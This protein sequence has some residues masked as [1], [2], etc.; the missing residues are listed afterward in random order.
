MPVAGPPTRGQRSEILPLTS[1][2]GLA[3]WWVALFHFREFAPIAITT[4]VYSFLSSGYHAVDLFFVLS[5]FVLQLN[6]FHEKDPVTGRSL[7]QFGLARVAR[8][9]PLHFFM[10][11]IFL[12]NPIAIVFFSRH[13]NLSDYPI[14]GFF[15]SIFLLNDWGFRFAW[16]FW[17]VPSWSLS[18]EMAA[19]FIFPVWAW[20]RW[21]CRSRNYLDYMS[22]AF[23]LLGLYLVFAMSGAETLGARIPELGVI[24]CVLQFLFGTAL[25]RIYDRHRSRSGAC[26]AS[27]LFAVAAALMVTSARGICADYLCLPAAFGCL[28]LGLAVA[29]DCMIY[30]WLSARPLVYLGEISYATYL[31]H[32]FVK[33]W[34]EFVLVR[35]GIPRWLV[36]ALFVVVTL[37]ASAVL[38]RAIEVPSRQMIRGLA[39]RP[40][41][42]RLVELPADTGRDVALIALETVIDR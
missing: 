7:M 1:I 3:A 35:P 2:R 10:M 5:G 36:F 23:L 39:R 33:D 17:N 31:V 9:W 37:A 40:V 11:V 30:R 8:V 22:C 32:Y 28:I 25:A 12:V 14:S 26:S 20:L 41:P 4:P 34:A 42:A 21:R 38:H 13:G 29:R 6:Y 16:R 27:A 18:A 15:I 19:Y 24:R